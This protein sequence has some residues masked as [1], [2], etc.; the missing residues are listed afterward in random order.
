MINIPQTTFDGRRERNGLNRH[1]PCDGGITGGATSQNVTIQP[2]SIC[3]VKQRSTRTDDRR[4]RPGRRQARL[5]RAGAGG[6][7]GSVVARAGPADVA[8]R[9]CRSFDRNRRVRSANAQLAAGNTGRCAG[10]LR[11]TPISGPERRRPNAANH[12]NLAWWRIRRRRQAITGLQ[13]GRRHLRRRS[14]RRDIGMR[15]FRLGTIERR[16]FVD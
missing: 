1:S 8:G 6:T 2:V 14:S 9:L 13:A 12:L 15:D 4:R 16:R 11:G 5:R 10:R 3:D 7:H